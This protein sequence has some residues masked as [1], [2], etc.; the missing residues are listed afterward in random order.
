MTP[1]AERVCRRTGDEPQ[2]AQKVVD[3]RTKSLLPPP[4]TISALSGADSSFRTVTA[5]VAPLGRIRL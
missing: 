1:G 2:D 3:A 5:S 4:F